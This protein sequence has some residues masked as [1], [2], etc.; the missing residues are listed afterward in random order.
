M[1]S[2]QDLFDGVDARVFA[3]LNSA[4]WNLFRNIDTM[5]LGSGL[6]VLVNAHSTVILLLY[7]RIWHL[8]IPGGFNVIMIR[9]FMARSK[10]F[11]LLP[12]L[13]RGRSGSLG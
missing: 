6:D 2:C 9:L 3:L 11:E 10:S 13:E 4:L 12:F 8:L 5:L 1:H 7:E